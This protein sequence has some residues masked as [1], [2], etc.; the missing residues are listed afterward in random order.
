[1]GG[2]PYYLPKG[3]IKLD[4]TWN[5]ANSE[6]SVQ[7]SPWIEPDSKR[8]L[9]SRKVNIL[10]D[11]DILITTDSNGLLQTVNGT[12]TDETVNSIGSL[13][14]AAGSALTFG[15]GVAAEAVHT[16]AVG[17]PAVQ[18]PEYLYSFHDLID[19][20][21]SEY[22]TSPKEFYLK[23][24]ASTLPGVSSTGTTDQVLMSGPLSATDHRLVSPLAT[25][26]E[27]KTITTTGTPEVFRTLFSISVKP[28]DSGVG[29]SGDACLSGANQGIIVRVPARYEVTVEA[30]PDG[31]ETITQKQIIL[32]PD[33]DHDYV[34]PISRVPLVATST[35]VTLSGGMVQ[36]L[37]VTA[38]SLA[39]GIVG[40]PKTILG[41]LAPIPGNVSQTQDTIYKTQT[42]EITLKKAESP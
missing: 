8:L 23:V 3:K 26:T 39:A 18:P 5:T 42:D 22:V 36:S 1:L 40:I 28:M 9:L 24:P 32:L 34:L 2:I 25:G 27:T 4:C 12:T 11:D 14:A 7:I 35:Q 41:M 30:T 17:L 19:P 37:H 16:E 38:P 6:W 31:G 20:E 33:P 13:V 29:I 21:L 10:F 15:A